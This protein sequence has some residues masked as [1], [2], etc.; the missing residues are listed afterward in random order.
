MHFLAPLLLIQGVV[1]G[2]LSALM[3]LPLLFSLAEGT[4]QWQGFLTSALL[5][6]V[7]AA[8]CLVSGWRSKFSLSTR[9]LFVMTTMS[10]FAVSAFAAL[11][12]VLTPVHKTYV[13]AFFEAAS[14][15]TTTGS[16][17]LTGL[18][19]LPPSTL[20]WRGELQWMGG[21]GIIVFA[22][23]ILPFL[24]VGGMRLFHTESSD[25]SDKLMPRSRDIIRTVGVLY[26][27]LTGIIVASYWLAGMR[28]FDALVHSMTT[29]STGG[30]STYDTSLGHYANHPSILWLGSLFMMMGSLPFLLYVR[31]IRGDTGALW[32]DQQVRGFV[33]FVAML[34]IAFSLYRA[35]FLHE[36]WFHSFTH[37]AFNVIS[38]I[39]TTGYASED[40]SAWGTLAFTVFFY[41]TFVGG[42]SGST[43]GAI[44]IFRFQIGMMMFGNQI[45]WMLH[46]RGIFMN[47]YNGRLV[48]DDIGRSVVAFS[49]FYAVS[50]AA[51]ALA[52]AAMGLDLVTSLS[53]AATA[54]GNVGPGLGNIIGPAGNFASLPDGAKWLLA[55]G[56]LLGRLE[57]FTVLIILTPAFWRN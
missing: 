18:E 38:I 9:Q 52:L 31:F 34:V 14:G 7:T 28:P 54:V 37:T 27:V 8:I 24:E 41:L 19:N 32:R 44:K 20:L 33:L 22:I 4:E 57:I 5:T 47:R 48:T 15:L 26:F 50:V 45:K 12:F 30:F 35:V 51:L 46:P 40:Y 17:T 43:S 11:P 39:T 42:C 56:M 36:N 1:L 16:T 49:F 23:A 13:D 21:I 2:S 55:F 3:L 29:I 6:T 10:W 25:W 53:G